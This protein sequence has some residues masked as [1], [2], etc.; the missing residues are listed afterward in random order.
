MLA[1]NGLG[2]NFGSLSLTDSTFFSIEGD[3]NEDEALAINDLLDQV[4]AL[5]DEFY[6]GDVEKAFNQALEIGYDSSEIAAY[7]LDLQLTETQTVATAVIDDKDS[8]TN[9]LIDLP[10]ELALMDRFVKDITNLTGDKNASIVSQLF[11]VNDFLNTIANTI[12][13]NLTPEEAE[14]AS[15]PFSDIFTGTVDRL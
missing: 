2:V 15:I 13:E 3:I 9:P 1:G 14:K 4:V 11:D 12:D 10:N 6:Y 5:A 7:M 8:Q